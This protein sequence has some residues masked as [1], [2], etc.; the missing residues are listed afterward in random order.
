ML[1]IINPPLDIVIVGELICI[2]QI[3]KEMWFTALTWLFTE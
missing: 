3:N 2:V 1:L